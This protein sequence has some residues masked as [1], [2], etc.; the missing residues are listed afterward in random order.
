MLA[1]NIIIMKSRIYQLVVFLLIIMSCTDDDH[2]E[3]DVSSDIL[4]KDS[5]NVSNPS[6]VGKIELYDKF[7]IAVNDFDDLAIQGIDNQNA[8]FT[9]NIDSTGRF[10]IY[11]LREGVTQININK[12]NYVGINTLEFENTNISDTL[13]TIILTQKLPFS[14]ELRDIDLV[15]IH[16]VFGDS[17]NL[18]INE[19]ALNFPSSSFTNVNWITETLTV[20][21]SLSHSSLED[22][23]F[24]VGDTVYVVLYA[25]ANKI[26]RG[27]PELN[28]EIV[29]YNYDNPSNAGVFIIR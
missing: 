23:G 11:D 25:V 20:G 13:T 7:G 21:R 28:F 19:N 14:Y 6:V 2:G 24:R 4:T 27:F 5:L 1:S 12:P 8:L 3:V 16:F 22:A 15:G 26:Y 29:S 18:T 10:R 17:P 9:A